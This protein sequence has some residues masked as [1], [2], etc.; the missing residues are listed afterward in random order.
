MR[1]TLTLTVLALLGM[2]NAEEQVHFPGD[3][4]HLAQMAA[5]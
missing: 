5:F 1:V 2:V 3:N 4:D